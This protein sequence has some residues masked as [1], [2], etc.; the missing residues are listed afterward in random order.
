MIQTWKFFAII[1][2]HTKE[3]EIQMPN[4]RIGATFVLQTYF[5][6]VSW[7]IHYSQINLVPKFLNIY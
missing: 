5:P 6:A 3:C 2:W 7:N 4:R 1:Q